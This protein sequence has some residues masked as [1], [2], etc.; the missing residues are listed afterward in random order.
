MSLSFRVLSFLSICQR[1]F[2]CHDLDDSTFLV[3]IHA[4]AI[5]AGPLVLVSAI[6]VQV[7][8]VEFALALLAPDAQVLLL[9]ADIS[10]LVNLAREL[11]VA[12]RNLVHLVNN[13]CLNLVLVCADPVLVVLLLEEVDNVGIDKPC[14]MLTPDSHRL[15]RSLQ[16]IAAL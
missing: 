1:S 10:Y 3:L 11:S 6:N 15:C 9:G 16:S 14:L 7:P 12:Q 8:D 2:I 5:V 13:L 4:V